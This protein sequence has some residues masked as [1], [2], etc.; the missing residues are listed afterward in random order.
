[1]T[2]SRIVGADD[3]TPEPEAAA[4]P[5]DNPSSSCPSSEIEVR[6]DALDDARQYLYDDLEG[7]YSPAGRGYPHGFHR[8]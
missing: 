2:S 6:S 3:V 1:M 5:V 4:Q 8:S 7:H